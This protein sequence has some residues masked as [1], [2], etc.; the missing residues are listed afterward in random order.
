MDCYKNNIIPFIKPQAIQ[1]QKNKISKRVQPLIMPND[2]Y[3][4]WEKI[5]IDDIPNGI[6]NQEPIRWL[7]HALTCA[8]IKTLTFIKK[9]EQSASN[10]L[11]K[12]NIFLSGYS[13]FYKIHIKLTNMLE[14]LKLGNIS[15]ENVYLILESLYELWSNIRALHKNILLSI[16][17]DTANKI[18]KEEQLKRLN[19]ND[20]EEYLIERSKIR[21]LQSYENNR[22]KQNYLKTLNLNHSTKLIKS[23]SRNKR[24]VYEK[25]LIENNQDLALCLEKLPTKWLDGIS[26]TLGISLNVD[27]WDKETEISKKLSKP[28]GL[29]NI[30]N[31]LL[32]IE[33]NIL[34]DILKG[35]GK[36]RYDSLILKYGGDNEHAWNW[37]KE[38]PTTPLERIRRT[39]LIYV[40]SMKIGK[41]YHK[42]AIIPYDLQGNLT[43][44][45]SWFKKTKNIQKV[46]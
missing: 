13:N 36:T 22:L 40:G 33:R 12:N 43:T 1:P 26:K 28:K 14:V 15:K 5:P 31:K 37:A 46:N 16:D 27:R 3:F 4:E 2:S 11:V 24:M 17:H 9:I 23:I 29:L 44:V 35:N 45:L 25:G 21:L 30:L 7:D 10:E 41:K 39:G 8:E 6:D 20:I 38:V 34:Q 18:W 42:V 32:P 19:V